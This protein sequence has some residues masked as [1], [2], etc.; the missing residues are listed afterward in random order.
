MKDILVWIKAVL[1]AVGAESLM[2]NLINAF[3]GGI[4]TEDQKLD[5]E[6]KMVLALIEDFESIRPKLEN[7]YNSKEAVELTEHE[8]EIFAMYNELSKRF[9][10]RSVRVGKEEIGFKEFYSKILR[11]LYLKK[12]I[13]QP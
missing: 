4:Q 5:M 2:L 9:L 7:K 11:Y 10:D 12:Q 13:V 3:G 8:A 1:R 6:A